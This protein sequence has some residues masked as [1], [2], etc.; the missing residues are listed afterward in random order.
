MVLHF[1]DKG[2]DFLFW[3]LDEHGYVIDC[4]PL[5]DWL[6]VGAKVI[7]PKELNAGDRFRFLNKNG[8]LRDCIYPIE[9]IER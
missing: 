8:E 2:Q 6:W 5:Q 9:R 3:K 4:Q 1:E 7:D